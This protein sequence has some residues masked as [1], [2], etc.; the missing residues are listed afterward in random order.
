MKKM[1]KTGLL[2][3]MSLLLVNSV[4]GAGY[5]YTIE[6]GE[7]GQFSLSGYDNNAQYISP[8]F[9]FVNLLW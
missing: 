2:M 7:I 9:E 1:I 3:I 8:S 6:E 5:L 4:I